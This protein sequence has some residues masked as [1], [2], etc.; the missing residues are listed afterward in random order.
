LVK[1]IKK[2]GKL[3]RREILPFRGYCQGFFAEAETKKAL[4][5]LQ[6]PF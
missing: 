2:S 6:E 3:N 5:F 1:T 4:E